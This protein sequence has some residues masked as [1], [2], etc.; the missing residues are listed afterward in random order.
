MFISDEDQLH[1]KEFIHIMDDL[2]HK[3]NANLSQ[4][5]DLC[6]DR[7]K[8]QIDEQIYEGNDG[9]NWSDYEMNYLF[10]YYFPFKWMKMNIKLMNK[11]S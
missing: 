3:T 6:F 9:W 4:F 2:N 5:N 8:P 1:G 7:K 10:K 11:K